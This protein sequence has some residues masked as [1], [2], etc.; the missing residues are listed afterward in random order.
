MHSELSMNPLNDSSLSNPGVADG[1]IMVM[2][3]AVRRW[4]VGI[5]K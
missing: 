3:L 5:S 4:I 2:D 1:T